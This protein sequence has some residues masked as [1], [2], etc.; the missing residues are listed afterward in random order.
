MQQRRFSDE[1]V[2][3]IYLHGIMEGHRTLKSIHRYADHHLRAWFPKLP[4]YGAFDQRINQIYDVFVPLIVS[5]QK[6][7]LAGR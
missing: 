6:S 3:T 4:S 7:H 1:E 5:S 2:I